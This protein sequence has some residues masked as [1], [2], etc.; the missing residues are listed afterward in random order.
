MI[1]ANVQQGA[2]EKYQHWLKD[3]NIN[4]EL[5][6]ELESIADQMD[7]IEDRFYKDLEFGTA[8][9]RG[10]MGAGTNRMNLY[11]VGRTAQGLAS[12]LKKIPSSLRA[13]V[14]AYDTRWLSKEFALE[15][16]FVLAANGFIVYQF[17]GIRSTPEL[18]FAVRR[19]KAA[20]GIMITASHNPKEYNG[21]K[22]YD[23][24]GCQLSTEQSKE[25]F[26]RIQQIESSEQIK[27]ITENEA[28]QQ[29]LFRRIDQQIDQIYINNIL[30]LSFRNHARHERKGLKIVYTPLHGTGN[31]PI[32]K[33][34]NTMG[35]EQMYF[36]LEQEEPDSNFTTVQYPNPEDKGA[37]EFAIKLAEQ[38][39]AD[40]VLCTDP[41]CDRLG[42]AVR[43]TAGEYILLSGNQVGA[44]CTHY[45]LEQMSI[46][47]KLP[48]NSVIV[49]S[50]VT[51]E[52]GADIARLYGVS[53]INTLTGFKYIGKQ[54]TSMEQAKE[55]QFLF[56]YEES[57]GYLQ[58]KHC[59][60]KDA[61]AAS[62]MLAEAAAYYKEEGQSLYEVLESLYQK[63]GYYKE[64]VESK[65][66]TG[67]N[68]IEQMNMI[69]ES[70]RVH[71]PLVIAD[72]KIVEVQDYADGY[73][74][75]PRENML[76]YM[77]S[78]KSWFCLRPSGTE[79]KI[80]VYFS[81]CCTSESEADILLSKLVH[82]VMA[83]IQ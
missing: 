65:I 70:F 41:D 3:D 74:G 55:K 75:L 71:P 32:R 60:D 54:I 76:K 53:V 21:L 37:L 56:G 4:E 79:P 82:A 14:I 80:K 51:N 11:T 33:V 20:A 16:A 58:G 12:Y 73:N 29:R 66:I 27:K 22:V 5:K 67:K 44:I 38:K 48:D 83:R 62:M 52:M 59:R 26:T 40:I 8:G 47:K 1:L 34:L 30:S 78:E 31:V 24:H 28:V 57:C 69:M 15:A 35:F 6:K 63:V 68:G 64:Q 61:V 19:L 50:I 42:A 45:L 46:Q 13:A 18:S 2:I 39:K 81:V 36:V 17:D 72:Q 9:L 23:E 49:K 7:E 10:L 43:N 25:V 77:L